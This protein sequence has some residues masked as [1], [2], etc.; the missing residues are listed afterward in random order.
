MRILL[1]IPLL[2]AQ[3]VFAQE[4]MIFALDIIR[5]G[6]RTPLHTIPVLTH[7]WA[8]GPGQLT[9]KGLAQEHEL[10]K[11]LRTKYVEQYGLLP[12]NYLN[13]SLYVRSTDTDRTLMSAQAVLMGLYPLG[14]GPSILPE[15]Y[16]PIPIHTKSPEHDE[17]IPYHLD[18]EKQKHFLF[19]KYVYPK[20]HWLDKTQEKQGKFAAWSKATGVKINNLYQVI[21][22]SDSFFIYQQHQ[23]PLPKHLTE[24]EISDIISTGKWALTALFEPK[25]MGDFVGSDL[26]TTVTDYLNSAI[27]QKTPLKYVLL[28]GHDSSLL[29]LLSA[30]GAPLTTPPAYASILH[31]AVYETE[32]KK[33]T[34]RILF[35]EKPVSL[36][37][38]NGEVC[39]QQQMMAIKDLAKA[40]SKNVLVALPKAS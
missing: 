11:R 3:T 40:N 35:N 23:L 22:I 10:G 39:T 13:T 15:G 16:Q 19:N 30:M 17:L 6:D 9:A 4:K 18:S 36:P 33:H 21:K 31:F 5:H 2:L 28:S 34:I 14:T 12:Q 8:E 32:D 26:L 37:H 38:C 1:F 20:K 25:E 27:E 7:V 24:S 29:S